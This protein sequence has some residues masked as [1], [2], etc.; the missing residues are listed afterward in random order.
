M[1][2]LA[3][4]RLLRWTAD[5]A[6]HEDEDLIAREVPVALTVNRRSHVVM[7]A[8]PMDLE[9]F[10]LGFCLTEGLLKDR[11]EL[12]GVR[13]IPREGGLEV[14]LTVTETAAERVAGLR[15]NL[16]GRTG[17]GL[18]GA[19][20]LDQ[21]I[22]RPPELAQT[23]ALQ[24]E[25]LQSAL[26]GLSSRQPLQAAAGAVHAAA[27]C[28]PDGRI[29]RVKEDVGRHNALDKLIGQLVLDGQP[30]AEGFLLV[31]SRASY[32][33]VLKAAFS[34]VEALVAVSA[35]TSLA[36]ELARDCGLTLVGFGRPGRHNVYAGAKRFGVGAT[37]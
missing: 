10:A 23:L 8:S 5:A 6:Y 33:M 22:R 19:E 24:A 37:S 36:I 2:A 16:T 14:A 13:V 35:P 20:S 18:C 7:M 21:A 15:R 32:E 12:L 28:T 3:S 34:G 9:A 27:W 29:H 11:E 30:A 26:Q 25:A 1:K 4:T 31:S 17:C